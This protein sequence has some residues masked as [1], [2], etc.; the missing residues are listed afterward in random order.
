MSSSANSFKLRNMKLNTNL[1]NIQLKKYKKFKNIPSKSNCFFGDKKIIEELNTSVIKKKLKNINLIDENEDSNIT[2]ISNKNYGLIALVNIYNSIIVLLDTLINSYNEN[3]YQ[4]IYTCLIKIKNNVKKIS[5]ES[6]IINLRNGNNSDVYE[7]KNYYHKNNLYN[8]KSNSFYSRNINNN[9]YN[10]FQNKCTKD[11]T[12]S[13]QKLNDLNESNL[14]F[15]NKDNNAKKIKHLRQKITNIE[16]K[17]KIEELNYLFCIGEQHKKITELEK[18]INLNNVDNMPKE[19]LKKYKC[20]PNYIKFDAIDENYLKEIR[21]KKILRNKC[22]SSFEQRSRIPETFFIEEN[23]EINNN[24]K[25]INNNIDEIKIDNKENLNKNMDEVLKKTREIIEYG[26]KNYNKDDLFIK[27]FFDKNKNYFISHPKL[28]YV[29]YR[30]EGLH[31]KTWKINDILETLPKKISK[32]KFSSKSQKN[33]IIVFPSSLNETVV[34][35]EKLRVNKN[36]RS[37]EIKFEENRKVNKLKNI[38]N[39]L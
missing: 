31:M 26:K 39:E 36:F 7:K 33:A 21:Q 16:N 19:E 23:N 4:Y 2:N 30:S 32:Y 35:L 11:S 29:K 17:F 6:S 24:N 34:N 5:E 10:A 12:S 9:L 18:K 8:L 22:H 25:E 20:F 27:K 37:I 3:N 14:L 1:S 15:D 13:L 38:Y 28:N